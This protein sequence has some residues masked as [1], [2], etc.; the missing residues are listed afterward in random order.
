MYLYCSFVINR[1]PTLVLDNKSPYQI[2]MGKIPDYNSLKSFGCLCYKS[3]S[4]RGRNKFAPKVKTCVF[5]GYPTGYK[6][7]RVLDLETRNISIS[8]H[9]TFH[10]NKFSFAASSLSNTA[11][12]FFPRLDA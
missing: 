1:I 12:S 4:T 11:K 5:L 2:L 10:E 7:Y 6:G 3:T 8:R 9:V